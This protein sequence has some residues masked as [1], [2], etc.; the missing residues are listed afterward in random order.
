VPLVDA[1]GRSIQELEMWCFFDES[2]PADDT[3]VTSV[4]ACLMRDETVRFL[5]R[6]IYIAR[7]KYFGIEQAK[8]QS[9]EIKG[10]QMLSN[11]SF[12]LEKKYGQS[13]NHQVAKEILTEC[14]KSRDEHP[15]YVLG[16][17]IYGHRDILKTISNDHLVLPIT[18]ILEKASVAAASLE[19]KGRV[20]LVFDEQ[21]GA[22]TEMAISTRKFVAGT[23]LPNVSHYP[24]VAV[25][26][27]S[28]GL[29]LAD[30][31]AYI[32]ARRALGDRRFIAWHQLLQ[33]LEWTGQV[34]NRDR[35]GIQRY[36][37]Q[38][39]GAIGIRTRWT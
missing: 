14:I 39:G 36:E 3:D 16:A 20:N 18:D 34:R 32:L 35:R 4:V 33:Q 24:L 2:Y 28:P 15:V 8:S 30:L 26:H 27:T 21:I 22:Q 6:T 13:T 5:D 10:S 19:P 7:K 38:K 25:S 23:R 12:R 31:G 37:C 11:N 17:A 9:F 29:Q 1:A